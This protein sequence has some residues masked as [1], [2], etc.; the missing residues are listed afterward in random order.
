MISDVKGAQCSN[1]NS[2]LFLLKE[3]SD[4]QARNSVYTN[5]GALYGDSNPIK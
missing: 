5:I 3:N 2:G 4:L 1:W